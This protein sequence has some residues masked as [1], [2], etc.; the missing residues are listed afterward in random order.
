LTLES[1]EAITAHEQ[2]WREQSP[3]L[4]GGLN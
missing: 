1:A 3:W 2:R 4:F